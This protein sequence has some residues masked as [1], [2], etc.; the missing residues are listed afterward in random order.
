MGNVYVL[1][2]LLGVLLIIGGFYVGQII[3]GIVA[4][5]ICFIWGGI[6]YRKVQKEKKFEKNLIPC[7]YCK[8]M[9]QKGAI[10]CKHC[11]SDIEQSS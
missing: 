10:K 1:L 3:L 6:G 7:P 4:G 8:E 9:I 11:G 2:Q 5:L